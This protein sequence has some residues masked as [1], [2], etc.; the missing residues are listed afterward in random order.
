MSELIQLQDVSKRYGK[1][2]MTVDAVRELGLTIRK[3]EA[4]G[5]VGES[6]SG[7]ST[8]GK[9]MI[10]LE[11]PTGGSMSYMGNSLWQ[12]GK[13]RSPRPGELQI[14]FQDPQS[15][16]DPRMSVKDIILEPLYA[17][18]AAE[19]KAKGSKEKLHALIRRVGLKEEHLPRYPHEFSGGQRQR[20]AIARA[21]ITDPSF[22]VLDEPTSALDVSVQAQ[23]L[24]LLKELK[25]ERNL[26]YLFISHNMSVIQ[27]MCDRIGVLY[28]GLLVEAGPARDLFRQP[29][30]PYTR[31]LL[32]SLPSVHEEPAQRIEFAPP[33]ADGSG[34]A[35]VFYD[36]CPLR[37]P[38]C[39]E[40]PAFSEKEKDWSC[41]C[42]LAGVKAHV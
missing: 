28:K 9:M 16:L 19:R 7:K 18:P 15:S 8:I 36:R 14:V 1:G 32:S 37:Q 3:G 17:L 31:I 11:T 42:H 29:E 30:H 22:I 41:A 33:A 5:L 26:T 10:G 35:C 38:V 12:K 34:A 27:Y 2:K 23:V 25:K 13:F 6:G 4:F 20:I 24:N 39:L 21:L 40:A